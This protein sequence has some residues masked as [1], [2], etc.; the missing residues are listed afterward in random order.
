MI[1]AGPVAGLTTN[2]T[3]CGVLPALLVALTVKLVV[4]A[5]EGEPD[6]TPLDELNVI[7]AGGEPVMLHA[8]LLVAINVWE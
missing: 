3:A 6:K 7:P 5:A 4:P 8:G 1:T 2:V